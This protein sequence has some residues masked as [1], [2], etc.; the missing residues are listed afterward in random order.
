[1]TLVEVA[2]GLEAAEVERRLRALAERHEIALRVS[3]PGQAGEL[4]K[5]VPFLG[6]GE[7]RY[8]IRSDALAGEVT[9]APGILA[10]RLSALLESEVTRALA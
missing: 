3:A 4:Q 10:V 2:H 9:R 7:A 1:M 8:G 5:Q 6:S